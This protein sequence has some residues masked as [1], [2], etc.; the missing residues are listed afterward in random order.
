M[1]VPPAVPEEVCLAFANTVHWHAS[2]HPLEM[3]RSYAELLAWEKEVG[4][5]SAPEAAQLAE[6]A[7][8]QPSA[9]AEVWRRAAALREA[10]YRV[11][12]AQI[13]GEVAAPGDLALLNTELAAALA[14][15]E[16]QPGAAGFGWGW[17]SA[18][19]LERVLWPIVR[20]AAT[21]LTDSALP[22]RV[23]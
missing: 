17:A 19:R 16:L 6:L 10:G 13:A 18:P 7:A 23:G 8:A 5:L 9:A 15:A 11:F 3:V 1:N 20:S 21:L 2:D 22:E 14:H 4:L 12:V